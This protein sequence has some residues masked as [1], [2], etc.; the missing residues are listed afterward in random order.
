MLTIQLICFVIKEDLKFL[1][2]L[3]KD[4]FDASME[5]TRM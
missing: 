4:D 3:H 2:E 5:D 1:D